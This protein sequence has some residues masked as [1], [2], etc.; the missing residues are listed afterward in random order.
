MGEMNSNRKRWNSHQLGRAAEYVAYEYSQ[1]AASL[2]RLATHALA[3]SLVER[4]SIDNRRREILAALDIDAQVRVHLMSLRNIVDFLRGTRKP[5]DIVA[6]DFMP[7][8]VTYRATCPEWLSS[9]LSHYNKRVAH[10]T[11]D[12]GRGIVVWHGLS[13]G[14]WV[15]ESM[16]AFIRSLRWTG[17]HSMAAD[18]LDRAHLYASSVIQGLDSQPAEAYFATPTGDLI[19]KRWMVHPSLSFESPR[20]AGP[21]HSEPPSFDSLLEYRPIPGDA[22]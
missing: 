10:L 7:V 14:R 5:D 16:D 22:M 11:H 2:D 21:R 15:I 18:H 17:T 9:L 20:A 13:H 19:L 12:R 4:G 8:D 3:I 1:I 6:S